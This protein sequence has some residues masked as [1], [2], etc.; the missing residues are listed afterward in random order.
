M[1]FFFHTIEIEKENENK[2]N[3]IREL[4][5][6]NQTIECNWNIILKKR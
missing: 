5:N 6:E 4:L 3:D 1:K 2:K